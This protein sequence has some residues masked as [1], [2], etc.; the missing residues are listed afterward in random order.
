MCTS[1]PDCKVKAVARSGCLLGPLWHRQK[2]SWVQGTDYSN[3][4]LLIL[5]RNWVRTAAAFPAHKLAPVD[6]VTFNASLTFCSYFSTFSYYGTMLKGTGRSERMAL[7]VQEYRN[8]FN[9]LLLS[10]APRTGDKLGWRHFHPATLSWVE[11][12]RIILVFCLFLHLVINGY[13]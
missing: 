8:H 11:D 10:E 6:Q 2:E 9:L 5:H 3:P 7:R 1:L 12:V 13:K 4:V